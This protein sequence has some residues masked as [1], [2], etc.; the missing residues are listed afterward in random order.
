[1]ELYVD[2]MVVSKGLAT[3]YLPMSVVIYTNELWQTALNSTT[4]S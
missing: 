2:I 4:P 1:M 3:S